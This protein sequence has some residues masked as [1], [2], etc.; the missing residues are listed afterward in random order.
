MSLSCRRGNAHL[1]LSQLPIET[2]TL[3]HPTLP[4]THIFPF[5]CFLDQPPRARGGQEGRVG[6]GAR[7]V[8]GGGG[9]G[10]PQEQS[11]GDGQRLGEEGQ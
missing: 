6:V 1:Y 10:G 9:A 11:E 5:I 7:P 4:Y 8:R 3:L 2:P